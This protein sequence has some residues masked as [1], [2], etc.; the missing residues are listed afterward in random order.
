MGRLAV[1]GRTFKF[2]RLST[3]LHLPRRSPLARKHF[4]HFP[5]AKFDYS[6]AWWPRPATAQGEAQTSRHR[7]IAKKTSKH[8]WKGAR[9]A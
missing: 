2:G 7:R 4:R 6:C 8:L 3:P 9:A 5:D 1:V